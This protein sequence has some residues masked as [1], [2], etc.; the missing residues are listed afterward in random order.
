MRQVELN[1]PAL[2]SADFEPELAE[3]DVRSALGRFDPVLNLSYEYK[4]K[5]G[6]DKLNL[7]DGSLELPLDMLFG[8]KVKAT[9]S[10]GLG[11]SVNP[12]SSTSTPGEGAIGVSLPL[13]QGIFTDSRRNQLRK[14][15]LRP[16]LAQAQYRIE[17]NSVL[18]AA[19]MRYWD[20]S[21]ALASVDV[22][23]S[24]LAL[25][26]LRLDFISRR[27]RAGESAIIDSVEIAQEFQRRQGE[28]F[29]ALRIA[30]QLAVDV[31][32]FLWTG[33]GSPQ[34]NIAS[35][36]NGLTP[37]ADTSVLSIDAANQ[38]RLLRPELRRAEVFQQ[39]SRMDS[40][41]TQEFLRPMVEFEA[42]LVAYDVS[43][44]SNTDYKL[45]L[46]VSQPLLF[47]QASA[48]S[49]SAEITVQR[50]DLSRSIVERMVDADA[51]SAVIGLDRSRERLQVATEEVRLARIM[52]D[53][54]KRK[55]E[56]GASTLILMNLRERF[57]AEALLRLV[58]AQADWARARLTLRWATGTI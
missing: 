5:D 2:R 29:R 18:R 45:G 36:P 23:D 49:Q 11:I 33:D 39:T 48:Q 8:P 22:A 24:L 19:G 1:H 28:R 50:A 4:D 52:V 43:A 51:I 47:R 25:A 32:V 44:L 21:E 15:M 16:D 31:A 56:A 58:S 7:F 3:A 53:A 38:A 27:A 41:L 26:R 30:E 57:L 17:R 55:F 54:E 34:Q 14:A 42:S 37:I 10:R 20:W 13:F 40:A 9:Y 6:K 35:K 12:Q 46:K